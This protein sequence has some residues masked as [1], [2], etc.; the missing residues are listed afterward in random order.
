MKRA[1]LPFL[2]VAAIAGLMVIATF[3]RGARPVKDDAGKL[4]LVSLSPNITEIVFALGAGGSLVGVTNC[5]DYP[6]EAKKIACVGGY[7][8]PNLETLLSLSPTLIIAGGN[9]S[10]DDLNALRH[11][12]IR[13]LEPKTGN[14]RELFQAIG[15]IGN[16]VG[17]PRRA[18]EIIAGMQAEFDAIAVRYR[19]VGGK[20]PP[21]VFVEVWHDPLTTAGGTSFIEEAVTRAGGVN[22]ARDLRQPYPAIS[23]EKVIEWNPDVILVCYADE[24]AATASRIRNRIGWTGISAVREGR[25][26]S[27]LPLDSLLRPGPRLVEGVKL[28]ADRLHHG[29]AAKD[30]G[31]PP[32]AAHAV[33]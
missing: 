7:G 24:G 6:P 19:P 29:A 30:T 18:A 17:R 4:R 5:C 27:D 14:F 8:T 23:A 16:A 26:I 20:R 25:I 32:S 3:G 12:G 1:W 28:L 11:S 2:A 10:Q 33:P 9:E 15:E 31:T 22:V 21:R 13:V